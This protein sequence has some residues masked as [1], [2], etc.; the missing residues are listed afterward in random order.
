ME[1]TNP[2]KINCVICGY[3]FKDNTIERYIEHGNFCADCDARAS[4]VITKRITQEEAD[5]EVFFV[6]KFNKNK[7]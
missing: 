3:P 4:R 6:R 5:A 7:K 1:E 2:I